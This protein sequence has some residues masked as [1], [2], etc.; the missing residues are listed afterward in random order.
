MGV[1]RRAVGN[2]TVLQLRGEFF[3]GDETD[4]MATAIKDEAALGNTQLVL[5]L[6]ECSY[7][8]SWAIA[9]ILFGGRGIYYASHGEIKL[10]GPQGRVMNMLVV[11]KTITLFAVYPTV[12]E[13]IVSFEGSP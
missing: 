12:D 9:I 6:S 8:N 1:R 5:D 7:M 4:E 11:T 10:C 3:G 13:A 2:I